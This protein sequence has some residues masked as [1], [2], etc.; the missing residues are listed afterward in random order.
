MDRISGF[1]LHA[2]RSVTNPGTNRNR[3]TIVRKGEG[4]VRKVGLR[5][6]KANLPAV[7]EAASK[8]KPT[9]IMRSGK[10]AAV[11]LGFAEWQ[12]LWRVPS[13]GRLLMSA[14]MDAGDLPRRR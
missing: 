2:R 5:E 11:V 12:R 9:M 8:G 7:V 10:A 1:Q 3:A 6:A 14:P 13:F 4:A